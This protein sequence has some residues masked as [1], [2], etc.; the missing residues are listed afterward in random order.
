MFYMR[1]KSA[2]NILKA[3]SHL[4]LNE[5]IDNIFEY[6]YNNQIISCIDFFPEKRY[7][8]CLIYSYPYTLEFY[9]NISN[10]LPGGLFK[11]VREVL[12]YAEYPFA[13]E[14]FL[15]IQKSFPLMK[16]LTVIN[17]KAQINKQCIQSNYDTQYLSIIEYSH[18]TTLALK[19]VHDDYMELF[20]DHTKMC[21]PNNLFLRVTYHSLE[22]VT[23]HFQR[24][25]KKINCAKLRYLSIYG[26][27]SIPEHV[28]YYFRNTKIYSL[29]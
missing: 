8:Q 10:K 26:I 15:R 19:E 3:Y 16:K 27:S 20:L 23:H 14:F 29:K 11:Y 7:N 13:Q 28:K 6:L 5:N 24:E 1:E 12:L 25:A 2:E 9:N 22:R 18:L 17:E 4:P 21:L